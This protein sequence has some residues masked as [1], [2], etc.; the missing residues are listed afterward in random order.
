MCVCACVCVY[1]FLCVFEC[2]YLYVSLWRP[3]DMFVRLT[4]CQLFCM[5]VNVG[6]LRCHLRRLDGF[7]HKCIKMTLRITNDTLMEG[8][9]I[10]KD[11]GEMWR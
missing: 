1:V 3:S 9:Y 5:A 2:V 7:H 10:I 11:D 4:C 6:C 8:L